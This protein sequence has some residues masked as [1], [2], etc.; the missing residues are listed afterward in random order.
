MNNLHW[1]CQDDDEVPSEGCVKPCLLLSHLAQRYS[2]AV[3][4]RLST[5]RVRRLSR[6]PTGQQ[7]QDGSWIRLEKGKSHP[8][9]ISPRCDVWNLFNKSTKITPL[10]PSHPAVH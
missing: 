1:V 5:Y 10:P 3:S 4:I 6:V 7:N 8:F 9:G 2:R